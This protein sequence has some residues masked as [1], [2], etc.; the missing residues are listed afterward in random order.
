MGSSR[1]LGSLLG[2]AGVNCLKDKHYA[3]AFLS[4]NP[5]YV[6]IAFLHWISHYSGGYTRNGAYAKKVQS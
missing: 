2:Y 4:S 6:F 1:F 3:V 5:F